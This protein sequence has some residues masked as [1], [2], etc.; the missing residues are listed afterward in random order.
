M[1]I[2]YEF[3]TGE[4]VVVEVTEEVGNIIVDLDRIE[5]NNEKKETRR[6]C[7]LS[8]LGDEGNWLIDPQSDFTVDQREYPLGLDADTWQYALKILSK[9]QREVF[10]AVYEK[11]YKV[12]EYAELSG[13]TPDTISVH[14]QRARKKIKKVFGNC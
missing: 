1:K 9:R 7:T 3:V 10:V 12:K 13:M 11:G 14:L 8:T 5:Y 6:H 4:T 2:K